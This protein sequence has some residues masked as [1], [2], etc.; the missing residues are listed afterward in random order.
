MRNHPVFKTFDLEEDSCIVGMLR[1]DERYRQRR[2]TEGEGEERIEPSA[3]R[4]ASNKRAA[5]CIPS[6]RPLRSNQPRRGTPRKQPVRGAVLR[7]SSATSK[8]VVSDDI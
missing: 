1:A 4:V 2:W 7:P 8:D 3:T 5:R 6:S